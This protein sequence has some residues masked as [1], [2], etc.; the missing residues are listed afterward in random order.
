[1]EVLYTHSLPLIFAFILFVLTIIKTVK[2]PLKLP[3]GRAMA[4]AFYWKY[5][6][7]CWFTAPPHSQRF[8][9]QVWSLMSLKL[10]EV[11]A[12]VVSVSSAE[13]S[14]E[15]MKTH[16]L[17]FADRPLLLSGK[18]LSYNSSDILLS[19]YARAVLGKKLKDTEVFASFLREMVEL[20]SGF[21]V[22]DVFPSFKF[23]HV[24]SG[25]QRTLEKLHKDMDRILENIIN[26]H[27]DRKSE[28]EHQDLI[29][30]L[31]S[32]QKQ[33][34]VEPSLADNKIK[35][36]IL[37]IVSDVSETSSI[38]RFQ[39]SSVDFKGRD[40]EFT[41]FGA[42]RRICPG[43]LFSLPVMMLPLT[44][45]L[46]HFDWKLPFG[47]KNEELDMSEAYGVTCGRKYDLYVVPVAY[48]PRKFHKP[49]LQFDTV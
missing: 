6:P 34:Y 15:I 9:Q 12:A 39:N 44:Q 37:G 28:V 43:M 26:E 32:I 18:L 33:G 14:Q 40:F 29:D 35:A 17:N 19:P 48:T 8:G 13:I 41:P 10:G 49:K 47:L 38:K 46:Y 25:V 20:S 22:A 4:T 21:G 24:I 3:P 7:A 36:I 42:G 11:S 31:L 16:D 2:G 30:V 23:L 27:R 45:M 1:M 5:T